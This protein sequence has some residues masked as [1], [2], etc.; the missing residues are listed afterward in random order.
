MPG[1]EL[2][3][4]VLDAPAMGRLHA[5]FLG[6][7]SPTD[8]ITFDG[9]PALGAAGEVCICADVARDYAAAH[10]GDFARELLLYF[11]HGYLHLAGLDDTAPALRRAMR[12]AER[13][14]MTLLAHA[15]LPA[16]TFAT[17]R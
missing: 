15:G 3:L 13:R 5:G 2:S 8:V 17:W 14:A 12:S 10:G 11:V 6:D 9:D 1:G 4:V 16:A 7:P